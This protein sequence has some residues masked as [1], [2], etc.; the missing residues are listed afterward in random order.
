M[1]INIKTAHLTTSGRSR[2]TPLDRFRSI[3]R[4]NIIS[5]NLWDHKAELASFTSFA[6]GPDLFFMLFNKFL[7]QYQTQSSTFLVMCTGVE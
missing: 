1:V 4:T 7:A 3:K 6:F 2:N 5:L